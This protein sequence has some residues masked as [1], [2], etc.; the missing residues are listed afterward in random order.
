MKSLLILVGRSPLQVM[1]IVTNF[2]ALTMFTVRWDLSRSM[3]A[4][5]H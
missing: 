5:H 2:R 3:I 1:D 4:R